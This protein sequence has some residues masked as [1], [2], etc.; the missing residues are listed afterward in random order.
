MGK[1]CTNGSDKTIQNYANGFIN[2]IQNT[3]DKDIQMEITKLSN[4]MWQNYKNRC[5]KMPLRINTTKLFQW[6]IQNHTNRC[7][8]TI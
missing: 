6:I 1:D 4:W 3:C 7:V 2:S 5:E 8:K